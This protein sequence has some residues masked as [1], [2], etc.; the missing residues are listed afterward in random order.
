VHQPE[1]IV[2]PGP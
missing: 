1:T 2:T